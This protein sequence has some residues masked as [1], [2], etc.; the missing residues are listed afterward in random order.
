MKTLKTTPAQNL[1][2]AVMAGSLALTA[3]TPAQ[4]QAGAPG[5][6]AFNPSLTLAPADATSSG[7]GGAG[8]DEAAMQAELVKKTLNP[9]ASLISVPFQNNWDFGIGP[10]DAMKYTMNFQPVIP[11]SLNDDW[12]VISRTILPTIYLES[13]APGVSSKFGLG[14]TLQSFFFSPKESPGGW[15]MGAGPVLLLPT[16]TDNALGS[17][18]WGA[19]PTA[20]VL[21]QDK[22]FTYGMMA[23]HLWS[24]EGWGAQSVNA[25]YLQP[26]V[27]YTTRTFTTFMV[28]AES[29]YDWQGHQW[30]VP[31]NFMVTQMLKVGKQPIT[32]QLGYRCYAD[33]PSGGPDWGLRFVLTFLFPK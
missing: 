28:N 13:T 30:S 16:A 2:V 6:S 15:I 25:T 22:G 19:G 5:D 4:A 33:G 3:F 7:G 31:M 10:S 32:L 27:G 29:T 18:K 21:R 24:F 8:D 17:G 20:V 14:D 11:I 26:F 12:N 9:I 1:C 23:N